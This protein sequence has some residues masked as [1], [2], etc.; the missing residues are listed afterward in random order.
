MFASELS[1]SFQVGG[2]QRGMRCESI[3]LLVISEPRKA[4]N[5][6]RRCVSWSW[7]L[8]LNQPTLSQAA[9][10]DHECPFWCCCSCAD[11]W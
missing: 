2:N 7:Q 10:A 3:A 11:T 9:A 8:N 5:T 4:H 6:A 1:F